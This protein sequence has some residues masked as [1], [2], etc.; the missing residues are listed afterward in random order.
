VNIDYPFMATPTSLEHDNQF[1]VKLFPDQEERYALSN[2]TADCPSHMTFFPLTHATPKM[3]CSKFSDST[4]GARKVSKSVECQSSSDRQS[5]SA[6]F[7]SITE[8][9]KDTPIE[10]NDFIEEHIREPQTIN[11]AMSFGP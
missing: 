11:E 4:F 9:E 1:A 8:S 7:A 6:G 5:S 10:S 2:I 3:G